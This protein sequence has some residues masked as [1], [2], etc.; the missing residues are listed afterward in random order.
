M[1]LY[2]F[3]FGPGRGGILGEHLQ[4]F[5]ADR[6][7]RAVRSRQQARRA[8]ESERRVK[9]LEEDVGFLAL[10][11]GSLLDTLD[12]K[13]VVTRDEVKAEIAS[14]DALDGVKEGRLDVRVLRG[15]TS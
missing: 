13:G 10:V 6:R 3:L 1:G 5:E 15:M 11:L 2:T 8:S 7:V 4:Q 12:R 9:A 14:L